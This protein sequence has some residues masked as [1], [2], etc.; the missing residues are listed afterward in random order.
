MDMEL[1]NFACITMQI[2]CRENKENKENHEK[3][4]EGM[5]QGGLCHRSRT[6]LESR[7][8]CTN[9]LGIFRL[10]LYIALTYFTLTF[11]RGEHF[12]VL[13]TV[14]QRRASS[15]HTSGE[16]VGLCL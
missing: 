4:S 9:G 3:V 10:L 2:H 14:A 6:S 12:P 15:L 1:S 13:H 8:D 5:V 11:H 7:G 16:L